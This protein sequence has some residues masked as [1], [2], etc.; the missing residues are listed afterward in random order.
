M[1]VVLDDT[2]LQLPAVME[3]SHA[4]TTFVVNTSLDPSETTAKLGGAGG[5]VFCVDATKISIEELGRPMPNMPMV[6]ALIKATGCISLGGLQE[7]VEKKFGKSLGPKVA[8]G[9]IRAIQRAFEE[10]RSS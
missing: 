7:N 2:L 1:V 6:G 4:A 9:N 3:G 10:V 8:Q 5:T